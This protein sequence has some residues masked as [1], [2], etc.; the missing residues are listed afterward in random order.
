MRTRIGLAGLLLAG[1]CVTGGAAPVQASIWPFSLFASK[2]P[3]VK[4]AKPKPGKGRNGKR[5]TP[6]KTGK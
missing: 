2:K 5:V 6:A 1:L 4:K 3:P